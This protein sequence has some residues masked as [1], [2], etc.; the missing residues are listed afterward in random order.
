MEVCKLLLQHVPLK[1]IICNNFASP[2][3][4]FITWLAVQHRLFTKDIMRQWNFIA[5]SNRALCDTS[6]EESIPHLFFSGAL[7]LLEY[8]R[9]FF[10]SCRFKEVVFH[11][12]ES[13]VE[14]A[15]K[16]CR[17]KERR[18]KLLG[19]S[20]VEAIHAIW[21]PTPQKKIRKKPIAES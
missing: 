12:F 9:K 14:L 11:I 21:I 8:G 18:Q 6:V 7:T 3:S 15:A 10:K 19:M 17:G 5:D 1:R 4:L 2:K 13:G 20:F 16:A